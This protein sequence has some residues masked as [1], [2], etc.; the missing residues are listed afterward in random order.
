MSGEFSKD[1]HRNEAFLK[2]AAEILQ[3]DEDGVG[4]ETRFREDVPDWDSL[5]GFAM[6]ILLEDTFG[7][8]ITEDDFMG[9]DT[10]GDLMNLSG[11][12]PRPNV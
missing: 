4:P 3:V 6:L 1:D 9:C 10:L 7:L 12:N 5:R 11:G 2:G 8:R